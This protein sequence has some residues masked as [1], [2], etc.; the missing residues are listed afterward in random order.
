PFIEVG[1]SFGADESI[2]FF[3]TTDENIILESI[4]IPEDGNGIIVRFYNCSD[5]SV[6][7]KININGYIITETV[8][9]ME[10]K[11]LEKSNNEL[12]LN[13]F[14]LVILRFECK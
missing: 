10:N 5:N 12:S 8:D 11:L 9:I 1:E 2:G 3:N 7:A 6:T 13:G 14:E 4:K